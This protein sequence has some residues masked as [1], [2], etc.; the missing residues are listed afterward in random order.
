MI[1]GC[2]A[3]VKADEYRVGLRP[4][5]AELLRR[6]GHTVL[7][8]HGAGVGSGYEDE[9]YVRAGAT[10]VAG[11]EDVWS[12]AELIVKVKEPQPQEVPLMRRGQTVFTYFHFAAD[13]DLTLACLDSGITADRKSV[14]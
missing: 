13:R 4:V 3:E 10:I 8:Q 9:A 14:V 6:A 5:G 12:R 7:V 1:V 11:P 2:P